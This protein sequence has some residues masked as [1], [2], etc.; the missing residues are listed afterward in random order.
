[1]FRH[2]LNCSF[3]VLA[4]AMAAPV[5]SAQDAAAQEASAFSLSGSARVRYETVSQLFR[6]GAS[7]SDQMVS[8][9][10]RLKAE[11]DA[12]PVIIGGEFLDAR[13]YLTDSG[14]VI[15]NGSVNAAE[16]LQAYVRVPFEGGEV[17]AGRFVMN[18]GSGRLATEQGFRNTPNN[19]EGIRARFTPMA[20]WSVDA[21]FT[22]P[23]RI[24]P[25]DRAALLDNT[26][27][28]DEAEWGTQFWGVH[29]IRSGLAGNLRVEGY[30][31]GLNEETGTDLYTPGFRIS[32]PRATSAYD[33]DVEL[34]AQ[35]GEQAS[36]ANTLDVMAWSA[37]AAVGYSFEG[38][39]AP[40]LSGQIVYAS[41]DD[42]PADADW[43]RFNPLFGSRRG[44]FGST[45][46]SPTHF[47]E[48][49]L[50]FG[51]RLDLRNGPAAISLQVQESY[52]ASDTDR[53]RVANLR[54]ATGQSG[55]RIG[56]LAEARMSYWLSPDRLQVETGA[57]VLF[58]GEFAETAPGAP[59]GDDPIYGY[60]ML[61][62][63]F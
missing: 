43:N 9:R 1:M 7:G 22:A 15:A 59:Q 38:A 33:F 39:W 4:A 32:R 40:R 13:A 6:S 19:F 30:L 46:L 11:Y 61:T 31:Y 18:V 41:G 57:L 20:N 34:M 53:W 5:A 16:L 60:V 23:V 3:V 47:R 24:A 25:G 51:P 63:P 17:Q 50:A 54:D 58:R 28:L 42:N 14:S 35:F 21:F 26:A 37:F 29:A 10:V 48:N 44:D 49:V 62:A 8:S 55:D 45:A 56:M 52:L 36:G 2:V 12:S 27:Q